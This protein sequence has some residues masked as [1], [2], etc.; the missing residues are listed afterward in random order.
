MKMANLIG[1][2]IKLFRARYDEALELQGVP[3]VYMYPLLNTTNNQA[4]PII[5]HYS[6]PVETSI[7]FEGS[8]KVKTFKRFGWVVENDKDLPFLIHCS[9]HLPHVQRDSIFKIA[10]QY[11]ELPDRVFKVQEISYDIQAPDH[12]VCQVVPVYENQVVGRT[13]KEIERTFNSSSHFI[14]QLVDYRGNYISN[15]DK[16]RREGKI[17]TP[18]YTA[19]LVGMDE[20]RMNSL[21]GQDIQLTRGDSAYFGIVINENGGGTYKRQEGDQLIF[22]IKKSYNSDFSYVEKHIKGLDLILNPSDTAELDYGT[23]WYDIELTTVDGS[24]FTVVGPARF[25]V[26]EEVTF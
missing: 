26:R 23:Y 15:S 13:E 11:T 17:L 21:K 4:E 9:F 20:G 19:E 12:L 24:V 3:C 1:E 14:K 7:F 8:P 25:I 18:N 6:S 22:T 16:Y 2:D 5:D 10:G